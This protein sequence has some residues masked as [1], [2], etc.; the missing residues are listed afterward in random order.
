[1]NWA[2]L[3]DHVIDGVFSPPMT[4]S[5]AIP[6]CQAQ[7]KRHRPSR[8]LHDEVIPASLFRYDAA[9]RTHKTTIVRLRGHKFNTLVTLRDDATGE[10]VQYALKRVLRNRSDW[11]AMT[12][13]ATSDDNRGAQI[14]VLNT[15]TSETA[16]N[17]PEIV[18]ARDGLRWLAK[19][20]W[21]EANRRIVQKA[22]FRFCPLEKLWHTRDPAVAAKFDP[23]LRKI[24][25]EQAIRRPTHP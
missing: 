4:K 9:T 23:A 24:I 25:A 2:D 21:S 15:S 10:C 20:R 13:Q 12:F 17:K 14:V 6:A 1:M 16:S 22:G 11:I 18:V 5:G 8:E 19:F 7:P 3:E